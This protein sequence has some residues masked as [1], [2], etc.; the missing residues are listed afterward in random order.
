MRICIDLDG[1]ICT[2]KKP[3]QTYE[4]V[5]P[6]VGAVEKLQSWKQQG[7]YIIIATARHMKT[8][9]GNVGLV[10]AKQGK[11]LF[12]WLDKHK[13]PY[14]EVWFGKPLADCYI[15][16]KAIK[17]TSWEEISRKIDNE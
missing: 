3:N 15:D 11:T 9:N 4:D 8:C 2:I 12:D 6:L 1:T 10:L 17:F 5:E 16:D 7:H 14:D 13:I